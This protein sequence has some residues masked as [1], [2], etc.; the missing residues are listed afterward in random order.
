MKKLVPVLLFVL[1]AAGLR[2]VPAEISITPATTGGK[3]IGWIVYALDAGVPNSEPLLLT[4]TSTLEATVTV[5]LES[6]HVWSVYVVAWNDAG[7]SKS[8]NVFTA[9]LRVPDAPTIK[10]L[11]VIDPKTNTA[12][13][14]VLP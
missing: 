9:D 10:V 4:R 5:D 1:L 3:A 6:G 2:A 14:T 8:S 13:A 7:N 11:V 12:T